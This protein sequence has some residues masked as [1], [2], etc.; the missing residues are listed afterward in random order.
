MSLVHWTVSSKVGNRWFSF[1]L[2]RVAVITG[3]FVFLWD[4][5]ECVW[6]FYIMPHYRQELIFFL[7]YLFLCTRQ[8]RIL[9]QTGLVFQ[10]EIWVWG[11]SLS[12]YNLLK[13]VLNHL[14][15]G[16][17]HEKSLIYK[18][19]HNRFVNTIKLDNSTR[20]KRLAL[21]LK[22]LQSCGRLTISSPW[23]AF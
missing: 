1:T 2:T 10:K 13:N 4:V 9:N 21:Q 14:I 8:V 22:F 15:T 17:L 16:F 20:K 11:W 5:I 19:R 12:Q 18:F 7:F 23:G 3:S 6:S